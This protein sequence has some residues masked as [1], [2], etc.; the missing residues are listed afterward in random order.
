[1]A[2]TLKV[3][4]GGDSKAGY[5]VKEEIPYFLIVFLIPTAVAFLVWWRYSRA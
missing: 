4:A 1:M 5:S 3:I 2:H